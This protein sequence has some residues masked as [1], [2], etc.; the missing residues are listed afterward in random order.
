M[1]KLRREITHY[2]V[3]GFPS[4]HSNDADAYWVVQ[5]P[6]GFKRKAYTS[7]VRNGLIETFEECQKWVDEADTH[8]V[9]PMD[10]FR[11]IWIAAI[12]YLVFAEVPDLA[13]WAGGIVIIAS[14]AY[15][16]FR[17]HARGQQK[18]PLSG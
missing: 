8:I 15:I 6:C 10:F 4:D 13:T 17:E 5:A 3:G 12:A 2:C 11:L 18:P 7:W 16:T 14:G 9:M 1:S